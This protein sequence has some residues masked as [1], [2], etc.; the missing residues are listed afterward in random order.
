MT[1]TTTQTTARAVPQTPGRFAPAP[2]S[3]NVPAPAGSV[4]NAK[5]PV[6]YDKVYE[7]TKYD[8]KLTKKEIG[9]IRE[10]QERTKLAVIDAGSKLHD[11]VDALPRGSERVPIFFRNDQDC[12]HNR[13]DGWYPKARPEDVVEASILISALDWLCVL[14]I[15]VPNVRSL[16]PGLSKT[17]RG[18]LVPNCDWS[19]EVMAECQYMPS[20]IG[21]MFD[22]VDTSAKEPICRWASESFRS[23]LKAIREDRAEFMSAL[24][25][26][27]GGRG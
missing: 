16:T 11:L 7:V 24:G 15:P 22:K 4:Y 8:K 18:D 27:R 19:A 5:T 21:L 2:G 6:A 13:M 26:G 1:D 9:Y 17:R 20:V 25:A 3:H 10:G 14:S 12:S 23:I